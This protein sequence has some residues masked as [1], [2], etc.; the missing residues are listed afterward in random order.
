[1]N[2]VGCIVITQGYF[3]QSCIY[4][5]IS[6]AHWK[7]TEKKSNFAEIESVRLNCLCAAWWSIDVV[8][9]M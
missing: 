2:F 9:F 5:W 8:F 6:V 1:M 7:T 3:I 4:L